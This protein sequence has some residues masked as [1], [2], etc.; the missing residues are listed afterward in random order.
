[1]AVLAAKYRSIVAMAAGVS[2]QV[3]QSLVLLQLGLGCFARPAADK[4][5]VPWSAAA[6]AGRPDG[7]RSESVPGAWRTQQGDLGIDLSV[8]LDL[9]HRGHGIE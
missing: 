4:L 5:H 6:I 1:M 3:D 8:E 7:R 2:A 9:Q